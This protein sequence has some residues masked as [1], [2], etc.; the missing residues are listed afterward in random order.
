LRTLRD[1]LRDCFE[2]LRRARDRRLARERQ[3]QEAR[4]KAKQQAEHTSDHETIPLASS[5]SHPE[6]ALKSSLGSPSKMPNTSPV[7]TFSDRGEPPK[8]LGSLAAAYSDEIG[9]GTG[10]GTGNG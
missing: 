4:K 3:A 6:L 7:P 10:T 9:D 8:T 2:I 5:H 1:G